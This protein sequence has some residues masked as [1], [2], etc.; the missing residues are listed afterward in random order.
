MRKG[1][2]NEFAIGLSRYYPRKFAHFSDYG[3]VAK[4]D[5]M[6]RFILF[7]LS[8]I[9]LAS[10]Q[11]PS[12]KKVEVAVW[13]TFSLQFEGPMTSE[14]ALENPFTDY[15]LEVDFVHASGHSYQISGYYAADGNAA[16]TSADSG[17][18]WQ[19]NFTPDRVGAWTWEAQLYKGENVVLQ[20]PGTRESYPI[21]DNSGTFSVVEGDFAEKDFR[22][23]GKL[24]VSEDGFYQL[25]GTGGYWIKAGA[26]SPEN[27]LAYEGFD[28]TYRY[29]AQTRDGDSKTDTQ[30][31]TYKP[32]AQDAQPNDPTWQEGKGSNMLG[33]INYLAGQGMNSIY[34]LTMNIEGD[35]K[36]VWPYT[37]HQERQRFDCSKLAQWDRVFTHMERQGIMMHLVLQ[38]TENEKLLD[39]GNTGLDRSLYFREMIARFGHH[40]AL[41]WNLGEENG[42]ANFSPNGQDSTQQLAM[43]EFFEKNDPYD[44]PVIIHTHATQKDKEELLPPL[45]GKPSLD[46]LAAQINKGERV[47]Q[48]IRTWK[49]HAQEAG[50]PWLIGMDEIGGWWKGVLP[51]EIDPT[52]DTIRSEV[53]WGGLMAGAA[54]VEW[55]FG[56][57]FLHNDLLC[58]DWRSRENMW[59]QSKVA[60]DF[61]E[62]HLPFWEMAPYEHPSWQKG[63]YGLRNDKNSLFVLYVP[64]KQSRWPNLSLPE[65]TYDVSWYDPIKGGDLQ[66]GSLPTIEGT[67]ETEVGNPPQSPDQDWVVL[68]ARISK[69]PN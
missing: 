41:T 11:S 32:H 17:N 14:Q 60:V 19:V 22:S 9:F 28:S 4:K 36:D 8:L 47:H 58:E 10:C 45:L 42:P 66:K 6:H 24:K 54:G 56:A 64:P 52:H 44:H 35:G 27:F 20:G 55:Y 51:D 25:A 50:H 49:A 61:F 67:A 65:G 30:I 18:I 7:S 69:N 29:Q 46:G 15:L 62:T 37:H 12:V 21:V 57:K 31:H 2:V 38:E 3:Q 34:F 53:L 33:A 16:E 48:E 23:H 13:D 63:I 26:D 68:L 40:L 43:A 1:F 59:K 39:G 5:L